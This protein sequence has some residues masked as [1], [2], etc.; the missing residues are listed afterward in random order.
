MGSIPCPSRGCEPPSLNIEKGVSSGDVYI[1]PTF[2]WASR[3]LARVIFDGNLDGVISGVEVDHGNTFVTPAMDDPTGA[4][5]HGQ[6]RLRGPM[7]TVK[8]V[9]ISE[10]ILDKGDGTP[11]HIWIRDAWFPLDAKLIPSLI[12]QIWVG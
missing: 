2:S 10:A 12:A 1:A 4:L 8:M 3:P 5:L 9:D 7:M 11:G 6:V